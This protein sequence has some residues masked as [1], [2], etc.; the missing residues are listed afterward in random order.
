[1]NELKFYTDGACS[2]NPGKGSFGVIG[3]KNNLEFLKFSQY[4]EYTT[5]NRMEMKAVIWV[6]KN[7]YKKKIYIFSDSQYVVNGLKVWSKSWRLNNWKT[8][9][10]SL[11][12]LELWKE[13]LEYFDENYVNIEW[14]KGHDTNIYNIKVDKLVR[15]T[16]L[17]QTGTENEL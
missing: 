6:L 8:T 10:G 17:L 15:N 16:I 5:S 1:M 9:K 7:Y 14:V 3:L 2:G 12:N 13:M 11:M 4:E